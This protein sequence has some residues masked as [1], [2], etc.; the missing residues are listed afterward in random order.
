MFEMHR[1]H[2]ERR[3]TK[4]AGT[5]AQRPHPRMTKHRLAKLDRTERN[6]HVIRLAQG[7]RG[8]TRKLRRRTAGGGQ[9]NATQHRQA[10]GIRISDIHVFK[11]VS[12]REIL[13]HRARN[14]LHSADVPRRHIRRRRRTRLILI[15]QLGLMRTEREQHRIGHHAGRVTS[16]RNTKTRPLGKPRKLQ[17]KNR[18]QT[19]RQ[20]SG[21]EHPQTREAV[22]TK[23]VD[24]DLPR[25]ERRRTETTSDGELAHRKRA[26]NQLASKGANDPHRFR[27][28]KNEGRERSVETNT[29]INPGSRLHMGAPAL[30]QRTLD[31]RPPT[32]AEE[33]LHVRRHNGGHTNRGSAGS[34][35]TIL[36][37][38][39]ERRSGHRKRSPPHEPAQR[40]QRQPM[41]HS[42]KIQWGRYRAPRPHMQWNTNEIGADWIVGDVHGCFT[43]LA[44]ALASARFNES[45]DRLFSVG[46]LV[47]RGANSEN[48]LEWI[49]S[50]RITASVAGNHEQL[51]R[52]SLTSV[53]GDEQPEDTTASATWILNG[54][55]WWFQ[56]TRSEAEIQQWIAVLNALP[57]AI[58]IGTG[59]SAIGIIHVQPGAPTWAESVAEIERHDEGGAIARTRSAWSRQRE[60]KAPE[61]DIGETTQ[62][63]TG[64]CEDIRAIF[65]GHHPTRTPTR[66][67]NLWNLDTGPALQHDDYGQITFARCDPETI[68]IISI[69]KT[70][71]IMQSYIEYETARAQAPSER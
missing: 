52:A 31:D 37:R 15:A 42:E 60:R 17:R 46:D 71:G 32:T 3:P 54:G 18:L 62:S 30:T 12:E 63:W 28:G 1:A 56:R 26:L 38:L 40:Y 13:D 50:G 36:T 20:R 44:Q 11:Q 67:A 27:R 9:H 5:P 69:S 68:R 49:D 35:P 39:I 2:R 22:H 65:V 48:A 7:R 41:P 24:E 8:T 51:M 4:Q 6:R 25:I 57:A 58:T 55:A 64:G 16:T 33:R 43:H 21:V 19:N 45:T 53:H 10:A 29:R 70:G 66:T 61:E 34:G 59:K 47:D 14:R 23:T